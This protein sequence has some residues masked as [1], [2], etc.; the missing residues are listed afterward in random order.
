VVEAAIS[1]GRGWMRTSRSGRSA[2]M[3]D[4]GTTAMPLPAATQATMAW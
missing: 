2:R 1:F 3:I 4:R